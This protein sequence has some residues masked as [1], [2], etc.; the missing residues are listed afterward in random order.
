[1]FS[2]NVLAEDR[3]RRE[4]EASKVRRD[5]RVGWRARVVAA[6]QESLVVHAQI[7]L[8]WWRDACPWAVMRRAYL[9][10]EPRLQCPQRTVGR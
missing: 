10:D 1:M 7:D 3:V 4:H 2:F 8:L 5:V 9:V 6:V